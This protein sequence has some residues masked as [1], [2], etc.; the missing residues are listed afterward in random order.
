MRHHRIAPLTKMKTQ[1]VS[2]KEQARILNRPVS[3]IQRWARMQI[4]PSIKIGW[5]TQLFDPEKVLAALE[6]LEVKA[7]CVQQSSPEGR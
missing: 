2:T 6:Q 7:H 1:L 5:R 4:I 3:T